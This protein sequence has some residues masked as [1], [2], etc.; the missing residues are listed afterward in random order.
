MFRKEL[1]Q[2]TGPLPN[3]GGPTTVMKV[4]LKGCEWTCP[5]KGARAQG[6]ALREFRE[7]FDLEGT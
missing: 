1:G 2:H 7:Q 5:D 3:P 6:R 4:M